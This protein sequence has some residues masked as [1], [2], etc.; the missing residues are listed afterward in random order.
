ML[1]FAWV[2]DLT[3]FCDGDVPDKPDPLIRKASQMVQ[4]AVRFARFDVT[5]SG[6]PADPDVSDALRDAVCAQVALWHESGIDPNKVD[7][8]GAVASSKIG[9][10]QI[11]YDS[12]HSSVLYAAKDELCEEACYILA[13]A[14]LMDGAL[15]VR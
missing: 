6:A 2:D 13:N 9:D 10:A 12:S 14:G 8:K 15:W 7:A 5:P 3:R 11:N 4:Y 1:T